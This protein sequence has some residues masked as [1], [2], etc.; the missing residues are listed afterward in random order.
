M[1]TTMKTTIA[2]ETATMRATEIE[3]PT[4]SRRRWSWRTGAD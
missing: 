3:S 1:T 4:G 2:A